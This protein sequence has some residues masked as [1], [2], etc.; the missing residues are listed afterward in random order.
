M[1]KCSVV[2]FD[3][4]SVSVR[5]NTLV[6]LYFKSAVHCTEDGIDVN[7][8]VLSF[9][10]VVVACHVL[11]ILVVSALVNSTGQQF[12]KDSQSSYK[13]FVR[14]ELRRAGPGCIDVT[15]YEVGVYV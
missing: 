12:Q 7:H 3:N 14:I 6:D 10:V 11:S 15:P 9:V 1:Y 2:V 4:D 13:S 5:V 8:C